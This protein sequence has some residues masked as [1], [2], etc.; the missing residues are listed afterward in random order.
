MRYAVR[1]LRYQDPVRYVLYGLVPYQS[2]EGDWYMACTRN[3]EVGTWQ[4]C[5]DA[6]PQVEKQRAWR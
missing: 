3:I 6:I 1:Q 4:E 2:R 5:M